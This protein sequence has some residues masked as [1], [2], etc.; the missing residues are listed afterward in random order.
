MTKEQLLAH[1]NEQGVPAAR[2]LQQ[3]REESRQ[4]QAASRAA[5]KDSARFAR[6]TEGRKTWQTILTAHAYDGDGGAPTLPDYRKAEILGVHPSQF[7]AA[8]Q[9]ARTLQPSLPPA[10]ALDQNAYWYQP[11]ARRS[12]ATPPE[13][14]QLMKEFWHNGAVSR[15][16][17]NSRHIFRE[18]KS[19]DAETHPRRQLMVEGGGETVFSKFLESP[20]F[21]NFKRIWKSEKG[22]DIKDPGRTL[23][24][25]T[26]CK[27]LTAPKTDQCACKIHTQQDLYLKALKDVT[28]ANRSQVCDCRWCQSANGDEVWKG[29]FQHLGTFSEAIACPKV[30]LRA[31]DP[32]EDMKFMGRKPACASFNCNDCGFGK[33]GGIPFCKVL[34]TSEQTVEWTRYEDLERPGNTPLP[35]QLVMKPGKLCDLWADFKK[36]SKVYMAHHAK[37]KWQTNCHGLCLRTFE[38]GDIV[39]ETDFIEKYTHVPQAD[40]TCARHETTTL[41][42]AIVHF[43][44]QTWEGGGRVHLS[45][46]WV[47]ASADPTHDFD[48]HLHALKQIADYY[49]DGEG[50]AATAAALEDGRVPR[51]HMF[52]D[53]C[54]KQYKGRRNF[55]FLSS[56]V[57]ELGFIVE[58][59]F[60]ATSHFKGCHDGIGGVIKNAMRNSERLNKV[61]TGA[62]GVVKFV[63]E[64][65]AKI[66]N[67]DLAEYFATWSA[68]RIRRVHAKLIEFNAIY[69]PTRTLQGIKGTRDIYVFVGVNKPRPDASTSTRLGR[70]AEIPDVVKKD[71][72]LARA[73]HEGVVEGT[74]LSVKKA[75]EY[76]EWTPAWKRGEGGEG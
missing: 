62:A 51:M 36:H 61:I 56:S 28:V 17:G 2:E 3:E 14:V 24:L 37:A 1:L 27:C 33:D 5:L 55:R 47:F 65:F 69:R 60:A 7:S 49:L 54:A 63:D 71:W 57:R 25:S 53:G 16:T 12:D 19:P 58:H 10:A 48:F 41:M 59:H 4:M 9:R 40:L 23:F 26:R 76:V 44:P 29:H 15:L 20:E 38:D 32:H 11:R 50:S 31:G 6:T 8:R 39:I 42:V 68:Y 22:E 45:E 66:G 30:D 52:T 34:E 75:R 72:S 46:T 43:C 67:K 74:G 70:N 13:L 21:N 64:Y 73:V 18:S 35:N